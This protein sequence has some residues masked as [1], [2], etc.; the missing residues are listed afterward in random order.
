VFALAGL[1]L[2]LLVLAPDLQAR[3]QF[4]AMAASFTPYG[5]VLWLVAVVLGLA[6]ARRR[7]VVVP[8]AIGLA[9]HSFLL[10]PYLP[11]APS[12]VAGQRATVGVL[13]LNLNAG[14]AD[15]GQLAAEIDQRRP[16]VVVLAEV[17][18]STLK[19]LNTKA[20][21]TR[22]PYRLGTS[23]AGADPA[24]GSEGAGGTLVLS[25]FALTDLGRAKDTTYTNLTARVA[26]PEHPFVIVGAHPANPEHGL[27]RW[28]QDAQSLA[29]LAAAHTGEPLVVAGDLNAT[30]EHLTMRELKARAGLTDTATG[31]GWHPT[32]PADAWYPPL[33]QIDHVL[34]SSAFTT[35]GLDT[36]G[37][38]G[39]DHRG[40]MVQ[41]A[42]S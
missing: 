25:R 42:V 12:A 33:I 39:T 18:D 35:T 6:S 4:L 30:A 17:T 11:G 31:R 2:L 28:L 37:V 27:G 32:Y 1:A 24:T 10:L 21:R 40:L 36:F 29:Q 7:L 38:A 16:D 23:D 34:V 13:E 26:M 20:W 22:M 8:L 3:H 41:L 5:W 15:T 14:L 9:V 19:A